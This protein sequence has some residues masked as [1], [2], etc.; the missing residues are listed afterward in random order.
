MSS[1]FAAGPAR[2][3]SSSLGAVPQGCWGADA[4]LRIDWGVP[5]VLWQPGLQFLHG[6]DS[7]PEDRDIDVLAQGCFLPVL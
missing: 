6:S 3:G 7:R 5:A 4:R 2:S 1:P